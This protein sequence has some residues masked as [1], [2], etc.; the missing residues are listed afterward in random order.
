[1]RT[2]QTLGANT[3]A[4]PSHFAHHEVI[5]TSKQLSE[6]LAELARTIRDRIPG[7]V[8]HRD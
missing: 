5:T 6:R 2:T 8:G 7:G 1:M 4:L 3:G